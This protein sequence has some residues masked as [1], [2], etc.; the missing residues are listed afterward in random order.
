M[1]DDFAFPTLDDADIPVRNEKKKNED[2]GVPK[3]I[4]PF[5]FSTQRHDANSMGQREMNV[6][7]ITGLYARGKYAEVVEETLNI[8]RG[9]SSHFRKE[10]LNMLVRAL[11]QLKRY[12]EAIP[13]L[14]TT[15]AHKSRDFPSCDLLAVCLCLEG[16]YSEALT[17]LLR[18]LSICARRWVP[19]ALM[20]Q[21]LAAM[22]RSSHE[23]SQRLVPLGAELALLCASRAT[24]LL[25]RTHLQRHQALEKCTFCTVGVSARHR[26]SAAPQGASASGAPGPSPSPSPAADRTAAVDADLSSCTFWA[27]SRRTAFAS[28]RFLA[29]SLL[30]VIPGATTPC[31]DSTLLPC[32]PLAGSVATLPLAPLP[33]SVAS[34]L[35]AG[36][37]ADGPADPMGRL[38]YLQR[39]TWALMTRVAAW[40]KT[41]GDGDLLPDGTPFGVSEE[42]P[43]WCAGFVEPF[44]R[45]WASA[46]RGC[47]GRGLW[48]LQIAHPRLA[49]PL[50]GGP[51]DESVPH[52]WKALALMDAAP[53]QGAPSDVD[54]LVRI[55]DA[56]RME[57]AGDDLGGDGG[58][59]GGDD[60][61]EPAA[62]GMEE[63]SAAEE[64]EEEGDEDAAGTIDQSRAAQPG[65]QAIDRNHLLN[66]R[67]QEEHFTSQTTVELPQLDVS[68]RAGVDAGAAMH[69]ASAQRFS[70]SRGSLTRLGEVW[71]RE[72]DCAPGTIP[73]S[74]LTCNGFGAYFRGDTME[75]RDAEILAIPVPA[76][77][78]TPSQGPG[79]PT[80][81]PPPHQPVLAPGWWGRAAP[82]P[83]ARPLERRIVTPDHPPLPSAP[84]PPPLPGPGEAPAA[85]RGIAS[86]W[87][88][89]GTAT[90]RSP[91]LMPSGS[92]P[93]PTLSPTP[94]A[95]FRPEDRRPVGPGT[96]AA[97]PPHQPPPPDR[98]RPRPALGGATGSPPKAPGPP[99][100]GPA[101]GAD[102]G[103]AADDIQLSIPLGGAGAQAGGSPPDWDGWPAAAPLVPPEARPGVP[104]LPPVPLNPHPPPALA[105][106]PSSRPATAPWMAGGGAGMAGGGAG[107]AGD[108][109]DLVIDLP[110]PGPPAPA[111]AEADDPR[112]GP[113]PSPAPGHS[114]APPPPPSSPPPPP[115]LDESSPADGPLAAPAAEDV[116]TLPLPGPLTLPSPFPR[117]SAAP[118]G[119]SV[120]GAWRGVEEAL[121][122][123]TAG[124]DGAEGSFSL[125]LPP[126]PLSPAPLAV[127]GLDS[128]DEPILAAP[129]A[130][131][132]APPL[133][134]QVP[135]AAPPA[136]PSPGWLA[137]GDD[138]DALPP[139][140]P[141]PPP[142]IILVEDPGQSPVAV[143]EEP[144]MVEEPPIA[145][146][147][148]PSQVE[149][150]GQPPIPPTRLVPPLPPPSSL[151][152]PSSLLVPS[153]LL[154]APPL[155]PPPPA[156]VAPAALAQ[157]VTPLRPPQ[158]AHSPPRLL[159]VP[160]AP[161]PSPPRALLLLPPADAGTF[162][163]AAAAAAPASRPAAP[164]ATRRPSAAPAL[165]WE[166]DPALP[167]KEPRPPGVQPPPP[168]SPP[169]GPGRAGAVLLS[170]SRG[171]PEDKDGGGGG[172][173]GGGLIEAAPVVG[174]C[175]PPDGQGLAGPEE[176]GLGLGG[177]AQ[178]EAAQPAAAEDPAQAASRRKA[179]ARGRWGVLLYAARFAERLEWRT[180]G[181]LPSVPP[182]QEP[183]AL[184]LR[185]AGPRAE[186]KPTPAAGPPAAPDLQQGP[187]MRSVRAHRAGQLPLDWMHGLFVALAMVALMLG[188]T[189]PSFLLVPLE[190]GECLVTGTSL[191]N[192]TWLGVDY[193]RCWISYQG[194]ARP[195]ILR[196]FY[197]ATTDPAAAACAN[198]TGRSPPALPLPLSPPAP[199]PSPRGLTRVDLPPR[200]AL[201]PCWEHMFQADLLPVVFSANPTGD[202]YRAPPA[203]QPH[204]PRPTRPPA[205]R[206]TPHPPSSPTRAPWRHASS[207]ALVS[208]HH[209]GRAVPWAGA[210]LY[211]IAVAAVAALV[212]L[213]LVIQLAAF[214]CRSLAPAA[215]RPMDSVP[216]PHPVFAHLHAPAA[217][218][219]RGA[220][221]A[222]VRPVA[223]QTRPGAPWLTYDLDFF[224][225]FDLALVSAPFSFLCCG[226]R[227]TNRVGPDRHPFLAP[228]TAPA[229][230]TQAELDALLGPPA[231]ADSPAA[232]PGGRRGGPGVDY[233][234]Y[235][236]FYRALDRSLRAADPREG[237]RPPPTELPGE[238][239]AQREAAA[240]RKG[241]SPRG[242][243]AA[244]LTPVISHGPSL[245]LPPGALP[246]PAQ[247]QPAPPPAAE[248]PL[249]APKGRPVVP[250]E[251]SPFGL[252]THRMALQKAAFVTS[253]LADRWTAAQLDPLPALEGGPRAWLAA[254]VELLCPRHRLATWDRPP[255]ARPPGGGP[256]APGQ[257]AAGDAVGPPVA[258]RS[259]CALGVQ[260]AA[261][262]RE[263]V[264]L[265]PRR[266]GPDTGAGAGAGAGIT[267]EQ[268]GWEWSA[269]RLREEAYFSR[270]R[271]CAVGLLLP[272]MLHFW[273]AVGGA[274]CCLLLAARSAV[275]FR[276]DGFGYDIRLSV[277][278]W[279]QMALWMEAQLA[280]GY[281]PLL[282][283]ALLYPAWAVR[284]LGWL[285]AVPFAWALVCPIIYT[286]MQASGSI[287]DSAT[288][289]GHLDLFAVLLAC[290]CSCLVGLGAALRQ[291]RVSLRARAAAWAVGLREVGLLLFTG[292]L[293]LCLPLVYLCAALADLWAP[294]PCGPGA[295]P[296]AA[297]LV[298]GLVGPLV[299]YLAE[300]ALLRAG[301]SCS[302][303]GLESWPPALAVPF[304]V[305]FPMAQRVSLVRL[306]RAPPGQ[307]PHYGLVF[308]VVLM[309]NLMWAALMMADTLGD[310]VASYA[311]GAWVAWAGA[312]AG[313]FPLGMLRTGGAV[314]GLAFLAQDALHWCAYA[315]W[316]RRF[317]VALMAVWTHDRRRLLM[318][319]V[320]GSM[321]LC[322]CAVA[323]AHWA[324]RL[325]ALGGLLPP[326]CGLAPG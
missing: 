163:P 186:G 36:T 227:H 217:P 239:R 314:M 237:R 2:S 276:L 61:D 132:L 172:G 246:A 247:A 48:A 110:P 91:V 197:A 102:E 181:P 128:A 37:P 277:L 285:F 191:A 254:W 185:A 230:L 318:A 287:E 10:V 56:A 7:H 278:K 228:A 154:A 151:L 125:S 97:A 140:P 3:K 85:A 156:A 295:S 144:S 256:A 209:D 166:A 74:S 235:L 195:G 34:L 130:P 176:P 35:P 164:A 326:F 175:P 9:Q 79:S 236:R 49:T 182:R 88:S 304:A 90:P 203:L 95:P 310:A 180:I 229:D 215:Y 92:P 188:V 99:A 261:P 313:P 39:R 303:S 179:A 219:G 305:G 194:A 272:L 178:A 111:W 98:P 270:K 232:A 294:A 105:P 24:V 153:S 248:G 309:Q 65:D 222:P 62:P 131:P 59:E 268:L 139:P 19:W 210:A 41:P 127:G 104:S 225:Q 31:P 70:W 42:M 321:A 257:L 145:V 81:P 202:F 265:L 57:W 120:P 50:V 103:M 94:T 206:P 184:R 47:T 146:V 312:T 240:A 6:L 143:V 64:E 32:A 322:S 159:C 251:E 155:P 4:A 157:R 137:I 8:I 243:G 260:Y 216:R 242:K 44:F 30:S 306:L 86:A 324:F 234:D 213:V 114:T 244:L 325:G 116:L 26:R 109:T 267:V 152:A 300:Q 204:A 55:L 221:R 18:S 262:L 218:R 279:G 38:Q 224:G 108:G 53:G 138:A 282:M 292:A 189:S 51:M 126:P 259:G 58:D 205:P 69:P 93:E 160:G 193:T 71:Q 187:R 40:A 66:F 28:F 45:M 211:P 207:S 208:P 241:R 17:W 16:S 280:V 258:S 223:L 291:R 311:V 317:R 214:C 5:W 284:G 149:E 183:P 245:A 142:P 297:P 162:A 135:P 281:F 298:Q 83:S 220:P 43:D 76:L 323:A 29:T 165:G 174:P 301:Q 296:L 283:Q 67:D 1:D 96:L 72:E 264:A 21:T 192:A 148:E 115:P 80:P 252:V 177:A 302:Y 169:P 288:A 136:A 101:V 170:G 150:P 173:G 158:A 250:E 198:I 168:P 273:A 319:T 89:S 73:N 133:G 12:S 60:E 161:G 320:T 199:R 171:R 27:T 106:P 14:R 22:T 25:A 212:L 231:P 274:A 233:P 271:A 253:A 112:P 286:A 249:A 15:L 200:H 147:D 290:G 201:V 255:P 87:G 129:P 52:D 196:Y 141:P 269:G 78:A 119:E 289:G 118:P 275:F 117:P 113:A 308:L 167:P 226:G 84:P 123:P 124:P 68:P 20:A 307:A 299:R 315:V 134:G 13:Y 33:G 107:M 54:D 75:N 11:L 77:E 122:V 316:G 263:V 100:P 190:E 82:R 46:H 23:R 121:E 293:G 238:A 266:R 63:G